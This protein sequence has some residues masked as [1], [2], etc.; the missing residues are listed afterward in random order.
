[1]LKIV[2]LFLVFGIGVGWL[3]VSVVLLVVVI[4]IVGVIGVLFVLNFFLW[5]GLDV[6]VKFI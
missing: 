5:W 2:S 4:I 3:L 1:M 6:L